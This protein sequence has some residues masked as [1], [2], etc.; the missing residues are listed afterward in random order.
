MSAYEGLSS[1]LR[2]ALCVSGGSMDLDVL[3]RTLG[4]NSEQLTRLV[5]EEEGRSIRIRE[6][7]G[8]R[9]AVYQSELRVCSER[10]RK[11]AGDCGKLH[12]CRYFIM[13]SCTRSPCKFNHSV[14]TPHNFQ[15]L[16]QHQ[17]EALGTKV[18]QQLLLQNDP[19]LL[20]D[21]SMRC[22]S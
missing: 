15:V 9:V 8:K 2:T 19:S 18:L 14:Q 13:G 6:Q 1:R 4:L 22:G 21:V 7:E 17:L 20:P 10:T 3:G 5:E 12:L 16:R 11:C